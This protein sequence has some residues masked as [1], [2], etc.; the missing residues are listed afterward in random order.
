MSFQSYQPSPLLHALQHCGPQ[1]QRR[2]HASNSAALNK[3]ISQIANIFCTLFAFLRAVITTS[4]QGM[5]GD[6]TPNSLARSWTWAEGVTCFSS[7]HFSCCTRRACHR[8]DG[9]QT[10]QAPYP[11]CEVE[12]LH[13]LKSTALLDS[14]EATRKLSLGASRATTNPNLS[15]DDCRKRSSIPSHD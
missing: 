3:Q 10:W 1:A 8:T 15:P 6:T 14:P 4:R 13:T 2:V 5:D 11:L 9:Q 12:R 7:T